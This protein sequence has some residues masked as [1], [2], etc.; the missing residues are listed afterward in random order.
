MSNSVQP[1]RQQPTR[2]PHP[3]D[4]PGKDTGVGC[5]FLL[6]CMKVKSDSEVVQSCPALSDP[7]DWERRLKRGRKQVDRLNREFRKIATKLRLFG[8]KS[9][10]V[11]EQLVLS[12]TV[13]QE[14]ISGKKML[15]ALSLVRT[16]KLT[17]TPTRFLHPWDFPGK[18][19][20]VGCHLNCWREC[21]EKETLLHCW[22]ECD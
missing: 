13:L 11:W 2:L 7:M 18:S 6:Q 3:W 1:H 22:W 16:L 17:K 20:G 10:S 12:E 21:E 4:F 5:H 8:E 19:T 9:I 14:T 15:I